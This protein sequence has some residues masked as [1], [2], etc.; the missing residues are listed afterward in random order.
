M[1]LQL[2][3]D[4]VAIAEAL[5]GVSI[6]QRVVTYQFTGRTFYAQDV[7]LG[8]RSLREDGSYE[9]L[10]DGSYSMRD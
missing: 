9:L 1:A 7:S 2:W 6:N 10:E 8:G 5:T 3:T 4:Q